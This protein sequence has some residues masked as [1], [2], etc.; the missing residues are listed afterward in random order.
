MHLD[1]VACGYEGNIAGAE[2]K[3]EGHK[4]KM[5]ER[6]R[7]KETDQ[8]KKLTRVGEQTPAFRIIERIIPGN[9]E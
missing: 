5:R 9:G 8:E 2:G 1:L 7:T 6:K 3:G 4:K